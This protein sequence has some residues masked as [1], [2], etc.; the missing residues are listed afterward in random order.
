MPITTFNHCYFYAGIFLTLF[1]SRTAVTLM[2][3][4]C[5][6]NP[7]ERIGYQKDGVHDIRKHR[8]FQVSHFLR[9]NPE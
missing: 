6:E 7:V 8:W 9:N 3:R 5:K 2:K 4:F 1:C